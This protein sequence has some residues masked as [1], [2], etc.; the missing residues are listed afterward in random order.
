MDVIKKEHDADDVPN[1]VSFVTED[2]IDVKD[3][4]FIPTVHSVKKCEV[5]VSHVFT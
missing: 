5:E 2:S 1:T 4:F 3:D